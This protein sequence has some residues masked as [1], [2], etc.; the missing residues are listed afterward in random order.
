MRPG[1]FPPLDLCPKCRASSTDKKHEDL[2]EAGGV[3]F[4]HCRACGYDWSSRT[5]DSVPLSDECMCWFKMS[6]CLL[7]KPP[8]EPPKPNRKGKLKSIKTVMDEELP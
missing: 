5:W 8:P 6:E 1:P 2:G 4:W 3:L 7:H